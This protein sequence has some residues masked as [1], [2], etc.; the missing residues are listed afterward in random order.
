MFQSINKY[1]LLLILLVISC[2]SLADLS[3]DWEGELDA[4]GVILPIVIHLKDS[5]DKA[6]G[7]MD[8]PAQ[9]AFDIPMTKVAYDEQDLMFEV[10]H[11]GVHYSG[12]LDAESDQ[13]SGNFIQG[14]VIPLTFSRV[15]PNAK[16]GSNSSAVTEILG[17]WGGTVEIPGN[18]LSLILHINDQDGQV[19]ATADSPDQGATGLLVD[20]VSLD[21][22]LVRF[23]MQALGVEFTGQLSEDQQTIAGDFVQQGMQFKLT[24]TRGASPKQVYERPQNPQPPFDYQVKEV[25]VNN[26][27]A[28]ITLAG[29]LTLPKDQPVKAAAV[30]ITGSGPQDRDETVFEHKPFWV[31]ANHLTQAGYAVLRMD[32]RGVG[33]STGDFKT[34]TSED[35]VTD[36]SAGVDFLQQHADIP[37]DKVGVIGHSEGG[38]IGP[39]LA[40]ERHDLAF[41]IMLAGPGIPITE[42]LA[43]Q[44]Y[45]IALA[46]GGDQDTLQK[47]RVKDLAFHDVLAQYAGTAQYTEQASLHLR[48]TMADQ[49]NSEAQLEA[50]VSSTI[51]PYNSPWFEYFI[52]YDPTPFIGRI[53]APVLAINGSKDLQVAAES[54]LA[55]IE[56]ILS[57]ADHQDYTLINLPGLNHLLQH[58]ETGSPL[59][60]IKLTTTVE[61]VALEA[62]TEWLAARF[63]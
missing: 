34:A 50:L 57:K 32:D 58:S 35:F 43:E 61:P 51:K 4:N 8:S 55:G 62:M 39:M 18:P 41:V 22:G 52:A 49:V 44:K 48:E 40:A 7:T 42:L 6:T 46:S 23:T 1:T 59:E 16:T 29:T 56:R 11:I 63:D 17:Q 25:L 20:Q 45:L 36:I 27:Q 12:S 3:G 28:G 14:G 10:E 54:N 19:K 5:G 24:L 33:E 53:K 47:Q 21:D 2:P 9:G 13:I 38:M 26:P 31:I 60:Y 15:D 37:A 30:M